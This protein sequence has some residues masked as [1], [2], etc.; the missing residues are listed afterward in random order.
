MIPDESE[1][2]RDNVEIDIVVYEQN[3]EQVRAI[4]SQLNNIP[5][6]AITITGGLWFAAGLSSNTKDEIRFLLLILSSYFNLVMIVALF[7]MRDVFQSYLEIIEELHPIQKK[8]GR[9]L[10][11][12]LK[13][14][15]GYSLVSLYS[16]M[17]FM[18][19]IAAHVA[20][21][22]FYW[23]FSMHFIIGVFITVLPILSIIFLSLLKNNGKN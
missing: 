5:V 4:N 21:Y 23:K 8:Q 9:T 7:R 10:N 3:F 18:A 2:K 22:I 12:R 14:L 17:L 15:K 16:M 6:I 19:A 11:A 1:I 13:F 20:A